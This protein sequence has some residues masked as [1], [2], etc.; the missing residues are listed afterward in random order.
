[1]YLY[2]CNIC[3]VYICIYNTCFTWTILENK[4]PWV[5]PSP[6]SSQFGWL[7]RFIMASGLTSI[8][9]RH[10]SIRVLQIVTQAQPVKPHLEAFRT[11]ENMERVP[12]TALKLIWGLS[13]L[14][15]Y[16]PQTLRAQNPCSQDSGCDLMLQLYSLRF[17]SD[18][19]QL[20]QRSSSCAT[21][22]KLRT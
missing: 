4:Q 17:F 10:P 14:C 11:E 19:W 18:N 20:W 13:L 12:W 16:W 22:S 3:T 5:Q 8:A 15:V 2:A 9:S 6:E 21:R 7:D 1:M